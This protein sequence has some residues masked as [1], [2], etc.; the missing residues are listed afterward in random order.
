MPQVGENLTTGVVL[1]WCKAEGEAVSR[2]DVIAV[3]ESEKAAFEVTAE[4]D[5]VLLRQD[6]AAGDQARVLEPIA[7]IGAPGEDPDQADTAAPPAGGSRRA[8]IPRVR[9]PPRRSGKRRR[10]G[11]RPSPA[12]ESAPGPRA[13]EREAAGA[14]VDPGPRAAAA[15]PASSHARSRQQPLAPLPRRPRPGRMHPRRPAWTR[16]PGAGPRSLPPRAPPPPLRPAGWRASSSWTCPRCA[17]PVRE[18]AWCAATC[19]R[20]R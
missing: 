6:V 14:P 7:W 3:V 18:A 13:P 1:E 15:G 9:R 17:A 5:G 10:P 12:A 20:R 8:A 4:E 19:S 16:R 2:G 11:R